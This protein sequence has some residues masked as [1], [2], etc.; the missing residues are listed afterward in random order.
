MEE[1]L[2]AGNPIDGSRFVEFLWNALQTCQEKQH[3]IA[4][5]LPDIHSRDRRHRE[6]RGREP[7]DAMKPKE[8]EK[9]IERPILWIED[10]LPDN[11]HGHRRGHPRNDIDRTK[12]SHSPHFLIHQRGQ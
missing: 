3:I 1:S 8:A 11:P 4:G 5:I 10:P 9:A 7:G 6:L 2:Y 12:D